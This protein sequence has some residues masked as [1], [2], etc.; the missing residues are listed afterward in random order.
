VFFFWSAAIY[1]RFCFS[2]FSFP[3]TAMRRKKGKETKAVMNHRTPKRKNK[4]RKT[5]VAIDRRTP[6]RA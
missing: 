2:V 5:K 1:R 3:L 4:K 6:N